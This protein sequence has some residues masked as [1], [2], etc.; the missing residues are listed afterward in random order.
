MKTFSTIVTD[1]ETGQQTRVS[2]GECEAGDDVGAGVVV[3]GHSRW[4]SFTPADAPKQKLSD[5]FGPGHGLLTVK[6]TG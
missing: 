2:G 5:W 3:L 4:I 1:P 6:T